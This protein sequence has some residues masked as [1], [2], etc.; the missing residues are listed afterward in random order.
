VMLYRLHK[1]LRAQV[2]IGA[3]SVLREA[4]AIGSRVRLN[5]WVASL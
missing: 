5:G 3:A 2:Q 1:P 4:R